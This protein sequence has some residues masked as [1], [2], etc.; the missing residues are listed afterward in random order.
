MLIEPV[1]RFQVHRK[2]DE[3]DQSSAGADFLQLRP[4]EAPPKGLTDWLADALRR[5]VADGR[6]AAGT[7]LPATRVL[8]GELDVS[9][10]V[11]VEAYQRLAEE[12]I[13]SARTGAGTVVTPLITGPRAPT[14]P[15]EPGAPSVEIDLSPGVPDLSAF[16]RARWLKAERAVLDQLSTADLGY[17]DPRG[18]P[19]LRSELAGWLARTRGIPANPE[20]IVVVSGVAQSLALLWHLLRAQ[21]VTDV[22]VEDP[23]SQGARDQLGTWGLRP[24]PV[25]V[26][27]HGIRVDRIAAE[28]VV[29]TP[30]HQFPT[31]VVLAPHRRRE[32]LEWARSGGMD[33][34]LIVE[35]DY[36]AEHRYDR[37]PVPA[38]RASSSE[39]VAY[40]GSTSKSLAPGLRLG[41]LIPPRRL[42]GDVVAIKH[43]TDLGCPV[44]PQLV[45]AHLIAT[46]E[47][48]RHIRLMRGRHRLR[49]D[50]LI[51]ALRETLPAARVH[52]VAA[53]I[54]LLVTFDGSAVDDRALARRLE[55]DGIRVHPLSRH[56]TGAGESGL[57]LG[58]AA[59]PPDRL[60]EAAK[61]IGTAISQRRTSGTGR[62]ATNPP[63]A[64]PP[65]RR[66]GPA[67]ARRRTR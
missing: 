2:G 42:L 64:T 9:R 51:A 14:R 1:V 15:A 7:R 4:H 11:V 61:R 62:R 49:R 32:L 63:R 38:L 37:A 36:D 66:G 35:D 10:G 56:R 20:E 13:V 29:V 24:T 59:H 27:R 8:A 46:G 45:L 47:L 57:V 6:L 67:A 28:H 41:W 3:V 54:H 12:G 31:G 19:R 39:L 17:G 25:P 18:A 60:R 50:A 55:D 22:A 33:G 44:I 52:G 43:D 48:D 58:Y 16:P 26:D 40:T 53:G 5:A 34:R 30:A 21:G 23:G 65:D